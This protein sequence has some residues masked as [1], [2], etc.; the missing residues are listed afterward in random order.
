MGEWVEVEILGVDAEGLM[1]S[2]YLIMSVHNTETDYE[3]HA[4]SF[5]TQY[6]IMSPIQVHLSL[7]PKLPARS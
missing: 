5:V 1:M 7:L 4:G 6:L 3:P 2:W